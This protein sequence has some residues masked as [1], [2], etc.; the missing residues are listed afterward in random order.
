MVDLF[1]R[2]SGVPLHY[3]SAT[4]G[5]SKWADNWDHESSRS[6]GNLIKHK[7]TS[8]LKMKDDID[9]QEELSLHHDF[10]PSTTIS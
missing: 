4:S 2:G 6:L 8:V 1:W 7:K 10:K 5:L 3:S 9:V